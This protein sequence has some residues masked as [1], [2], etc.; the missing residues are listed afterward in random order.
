MADVR[1]PSGCRTTVI[2]ATGTRL[3]AM[4][5]GAGLEYHG[6]EQV[7]RVLVRYPLKVVR[8]DVDPAR[9]PFGLMLDC[10]DGTPQRIEVPA[11]ETPARRGLG[12]SP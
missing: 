7:K 8:A 1:D 4:A 5:S 6:A 3:V 11:V 9:N 10:Y 12:V 2:A